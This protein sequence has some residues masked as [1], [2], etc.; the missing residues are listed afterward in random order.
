M[1]RAGS[2]TLGSGG[3]SGAG[4]A[5]ERRFV[6]EGT[7]VVLVRQV[8]GGVVFEQPVDEEFERPPRVEAGGAR[9]WPGVVLPDCGIRYSSDV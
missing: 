1:I 7:Q 5:L 3:G 4:G 6:D 2:K 9:V 8:E